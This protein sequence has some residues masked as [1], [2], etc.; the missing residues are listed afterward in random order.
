[1]TRICCYCREECDP[2]MKSGSPEE[3]HFDDEAYHVR[4]M[5][6]SSDGQP[7]M[8]PPGS[9]GQV[10]V[11]ALHKLV[12]VARDEGLK[13]AA[14]RDI[15]LELDREKHPKAEHL[16]GLI[17]AYLR[18]ETQAEEMLRRLVPPTVPKI[19]AGLAG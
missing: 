7:V 17:D 12:Q 16:R 3:W 6:Q 2:K 19:P 9:T 8:G 14:T 13:A 18:M 10:A 4:C 5:L 15:Y 1:M 11:Q